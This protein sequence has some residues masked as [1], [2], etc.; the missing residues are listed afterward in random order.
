MLQKVLGEMDG[1]IKAFDKLTPSKQQK[2][3][4]QSPLV[5]KSPSKPKSSSTS[6]SPIKK[7]IVTRKDGPPPLSA[8]IMLLHP[9][10]KPSKLY[11]V[12]SQKGNRGG[13]GVGSRSRES[14]ISPSR[15]GGFQNINDVDDYMN[16][17]GRYSNRD[18]EGDGGSGSDD[19]G[20]DQD[21][22]LSRKRRS[23][24]DNELNGSFNGS[25]S[26]DQRIREKTPRAGTRVL[27]PLHPN[28]ASPPK[29]NTQQQD[30][31][32]ASAFFNR[33]GTGGGSGSSDEDDDKRHGY[34]NKYIYYIY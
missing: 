24:G 10:L 16:Q 9:S 32:S 34:I 14:S 11:D 29:T 6:T 7:E 19:S 8:G 26:R 21:K 1:L 17:R 22:R 20:N 31:A 2:F 33:G 12:P 25:S 18:N 13:I 23:F 4:H 27:P 5:P 3:S 30:N 28:T 15:N